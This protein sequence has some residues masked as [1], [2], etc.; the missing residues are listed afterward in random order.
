MRYFFS[1]ALLCLFSSFSAQ[2]VITYPYNPDSNGD[3]FVA[4]PDMLETLAF[5]GSVFTPAEI[6]IDGVGLLQVILD[7]QN[8]LGA[9][10]QDIASL[11]SDNIALTQQIIDLQ[12]AGF[13][14]F[15][16]AYSSLSGIPSMAWVDLSFAN[17]SDDYLSNINLSYA[18]LS[19]CN[20]MSSNLIN[21]NLSYSDLSYSDLTSAT[22]NNAN[23]FNADLTGTNLFNASLTSANLVSA[24]FTGANLF[25][26]DL[27]NAIIQDVIWEGAYILGCI[28]CP[29]TDADNNYYCD[30]EIE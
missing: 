22:L 10:Q 4:T 16:G 18:T 8:Q 12:N 5:F 1:I 11:Q 25:N 9:F 23:L 13:S 28:G 2:S 26:T 15:D 21:A 24:N 14:T 19:N 30:P 7:L 27:S 20:F 29:C 3:A 6:Q 17:L